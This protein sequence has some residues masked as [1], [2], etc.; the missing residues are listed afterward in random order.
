[1]STAVDSSRPRRFACLSIDMEPDLRCP[2]K[3]IRLLDD[4]KYFSAFSELLRE[5]AVPLTSFTVMSAAPRFI[6]RLNAL[7]GEID[8]EFA[9][10]SYSHD[11][12]N[13]ASEYEV[14]R[15]WEVFGELWNAAPQ[16]YRS[17]NCLIDERGI[18]TLA[19]RGFRYDS[20]I[21][22]SVRP[23]K[24]AYDNR[25]YGRLPFRFEGPNGTLLEF[26][27]ACLAGIRLPLIFSY[28]KLLGLLAYRSA[29]QAFPLPDVVVT[30]LHPYDLYVDEIAQ[31]IPGWKRRAHSRN[32]RRAFPLLA[33]I[34]ALLKDRGYEFVLMRDLADAFASRDLAVHTLATLT[35]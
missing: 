15:A 19:A 28:V 16:G 32:S 27:I 13:P 34:I 9:V 20:S 12:D 3:R 31:Y 5:H 24:Y 10:H 22:P 11:T 23:D 18:D 1:M 14:R 30:Y 25:R 6:D 8:I 4:D 29:L 17:P 2:D 33:Q 35:R 7:A 21:V 26:P